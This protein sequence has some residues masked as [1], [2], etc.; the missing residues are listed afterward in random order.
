MGRKVHPYGFRMGVTKDWQ[1][2][3]FSERGYADL[4]HEDLR[5]RKVV[6]DRL[7]DAGISEIIIDRNANQLT[8]TVKTAKPGIVIGRGGANVEQLRNALEEATDRRVRLN[9]E[10]IRVP[11][12][13]AFLVARSV[14]D[15]LERRVAFRRA[16]KQAVQRTMQRGAEG[17]KIKIGGRLGG[18]EMSRSEYELQGRVPLHTLRAD[19]DYGQ[20]EAR[21]TF[22]VVGVKCW[23]YKGDIAPDQSPF[24]LAGIEESE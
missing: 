7:P 8:L 3:W 5:M 2:K 10:E 9:I 12:T 4:V 6:L 11:E 18:A 20:A 23:I 24:A 14:A 13:D 17:C 19:I 1:A 21:T 16:M 22:G 15:Q